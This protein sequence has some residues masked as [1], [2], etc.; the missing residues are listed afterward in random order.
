MNIHRF[1]GGLFAA[2]LLTTTALAQPFFGS[3]DFNDNSFASG[4]WQSFGTNG[5]GLWTETN[6]R[7]EFT[8]DAS[9]TGTY[10]T[11]NRV[12][13]SRLWSNNTANTSYTTDWNASASFTIDTAVVATNG[14][15]TLGLNTFASTTDAGYY[16]I[17]LLAATNGNRIFT[18]RGIWNGTGYNRV[19]L[20]STGTLDLGFDV[21]DVLLQI[22][23]DASTQTLNTSFSFDSGAT[24]ADFTTVGSGDR[25]GGA[26]NFA[27]ANWADSVVDGFG[28]D[29]YGTTYGN[30][31]TPTGPT[32][33]SGQAYMDNL[34]ISA[35]PEP[36]TY[37]AIAGALMLGFAAW[38]RRAKR[39]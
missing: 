7:M 9:D 26:A 30:N 2:A 29:I 10:S 32:V 20:G 3:D 12:Q 28:L 22:N 11:S 38:K 14:V 36:S 17:Y 31:S 6:G 15:V 1:A 25:F 37:A 5:G 27:V 33:L 23:Y 16:G 19:T 18:E 35:V 21:T 24:Y 39:A 4:R 13:Q 34:S 8:G